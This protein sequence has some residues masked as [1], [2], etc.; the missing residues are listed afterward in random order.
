MEPAVIGM[1]GFSALNRNAAGNCV[2]VIEPCLMNGICGHWCGPENRDV[3]VL[4]W[5][6]QE[7]FLQLYRERKQSGSPQSSCCCGGSSGRVDH[8]WMYQFKNRILDLFHI[9]NFLPQKCQA[10]W[11][12][13]TIPAFRRLSKEEPFEFQA[14]LGYVLCSRPAWA[15]QWD[16]IS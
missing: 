16:P 11:H 2:L 1:V 3:H 13:A 5:K 14:S 9:F 10:C 12:R 7:P 6:E 15:T 8:G 4:H